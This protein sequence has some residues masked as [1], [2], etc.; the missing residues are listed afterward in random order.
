[1]VLS[2]GHLQ[3]MEGYWIPVVDPRQT[4]DL[5]TLDRFCPLIDCLFRSWFGEEHTM[6]SLQLWQY[7]MLMNLD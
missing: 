4:Y 2:R 5:F 1:M 7:G 6:V 3:E